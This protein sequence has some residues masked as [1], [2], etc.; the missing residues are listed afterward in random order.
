MQLAEA[1]CVAS[2]R[3]QVR[4]SLSRLAKTRN[5][6]LVALDNCVQCLSLCCAISMLQMD[7]VVFSSAFSEARGEHLQNTVQAGDL[8]WTF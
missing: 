8:G 3:T 4:E 5:K 1:E 2:Q 6:G 7:E